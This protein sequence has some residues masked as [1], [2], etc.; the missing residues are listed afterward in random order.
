MK[1]MNENLDNYNLLGERGSYSK[2]S[3]VHREFSLC[4][5]R[6]RL[7]NVSHIYYV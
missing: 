4:I 6:L 5:I 7:S 2:I 1:S 3:C